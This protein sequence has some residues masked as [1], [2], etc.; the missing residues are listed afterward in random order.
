MKN[1]AKQGAP[2]LPSSAVSLVSK[3][4]FCTISAKKSPE[5]FFRVSSIKTLPRCVSTA[6]TVIALQPFVLAI[7]KVSEIHK[8]AARSFVVAKFRASALRSQQSVCPFV[9]TSND[10]YLAAYHLISSLRHPSF[11]ILAISFKSDV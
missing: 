9:F 3:W 5:K 1:A 6:A 10:T 2:V 4:V 7:R 8:R 11:T